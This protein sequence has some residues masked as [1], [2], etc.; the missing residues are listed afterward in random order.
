MRFLLAALALLAFPPTLLAQSFNVDVGDNTILFPVPVD[1]YGAA[2]AQTGRWNNVKFPYNAALVNLDGTASSVTTSSTSSSSYNYFPSSLT[3]EDRNFMID[4]QNLPNLGGPWSWTF[5]GLANGNYTLYTYAWAPENNGN[6]TRVHVPISSD[7]PQ[8]V[9]GLWS[10]SPHVLGVTYALHHFTV[11]NG[12]VVVQVEGLAGH[13]GSV[14]G[15]QFEYLSGPVSYC[16]AK[17]NSLGCT[18]VIGSSGTP[19]ASSGSGFTVQASNVI[20]N[21]SG[22]LFYGIT[23]RAALPFQGGTLCVKA[24]IRRTPVV[25][26]GGLPPPNS[27]TG[28]YFID[29]NAFAHSTGT[30]APSPALLVPGTIVDCQW[31]GRDPG[32]PVPNNTTLSDGLEYTVGP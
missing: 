3:G 10:G 4:I 29:M 11:T 27:C 15:F 1:G 23:G 32:F 2:A 19:S 31:W 17:M 28:T 7:L 30:P 12:V 14:N 5:S 24:P 13:D 8:D 26:S 25:S 16:T 18:P 6:P 9:G 22:L 20:N 21:K